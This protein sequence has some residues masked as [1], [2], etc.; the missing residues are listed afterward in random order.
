MTYD[1]V[2]ENIGTIAKSGTAGFL[3]A[4][5]AAPSRAL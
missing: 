5:G 2:V 1:E 3:E 4:V